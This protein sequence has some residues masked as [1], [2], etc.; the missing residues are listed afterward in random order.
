[1]ILL[2][3]TRQHGCQTFSNLQTTGLNYRPTA[4]LRVVQ[5][6]ML[7][8]IHCIDDRAD[9]LIVCLVFWQLTLIS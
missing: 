5:I 3:L 7:Y 1:M 8:I 9:A 4:E 6:T 2:G